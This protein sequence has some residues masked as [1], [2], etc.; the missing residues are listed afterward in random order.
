MYSREQSYEFVLFWIDILV[1]INEDDVETRSIL[2][3]DIGIFFKERDRFF[4]EVVK[5]K[6]IVS[7]ERPFIFFKNR[8]DKRLPLGGL[9]AVFYGTL[10]IF[11]LRDLLRKK[12]RA[13]FFIFFFCLVRR[14]GGFDDLFKEV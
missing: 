1:F 14:D 3:E 5:I 4:Y 10:Q 13:I 11:Y 8:R 6:S 12:C 7:R 9:C 2:F